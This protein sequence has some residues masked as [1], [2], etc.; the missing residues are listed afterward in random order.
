MITITLDTN[1]ESHLE[2]FIRL[3][4][5]LKI[6]ITVNKSNEETSVLDE[7]DDP[8]SLTDFFQKHKLSKKNRQ[9]F[10]ELHYS[11]E[12]CNA[13]ARGEVEPVMTYEDL[14]I[15]L[16]QIAENENRTYETV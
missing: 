6:A 8:Q 2:R 16:K 5:Q 7:N 9:F 10:R 11:I 15:E 3:A 14:L 1:Q 4:E 13:L 12:E